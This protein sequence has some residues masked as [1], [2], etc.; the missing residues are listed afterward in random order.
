VLISSEVLAAPFDFTLAI[1][2]RVAPSFTARL[3]LFTQKK[4][5]SKVN[6]SLAA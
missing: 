6:S 4:P 1:L 2:N 3:F 5:G